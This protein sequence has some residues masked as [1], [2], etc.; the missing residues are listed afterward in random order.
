MCYDLVKSRPYVQNLLHSKLR[1]DRHYEICH[2]LKKCIW[3]TPDEVRA[4]NRAREQ[5]LEEYLI[6]LA[7][8]ANDVFNE[9][10]DDEKDSEN[11]EEL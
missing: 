11:A 9:E 7:D 4:I 5:A 1:R 10:D 6:A 3:K 8:E 2:T